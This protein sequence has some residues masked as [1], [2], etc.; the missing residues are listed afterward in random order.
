MKAPP[1]IFRGGGTDVKTFYS[2]IDMS[3]VKT[4][5]RYR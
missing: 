5:D 2:E 4:E 1:L 3:V